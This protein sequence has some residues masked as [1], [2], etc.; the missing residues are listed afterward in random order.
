LRRT[1]TEVLL[2]GPHPWQNPVDP[3][4]VNGD[5]EVTPLDVLIMINGLNAG[6]GGPLPTAPTPDY[7]PTQLIS[8]HIP[9]ARHAIRPPDFHLSA[10]CGGFRVARLEPARRSGG[11][12]TAEIA[13]RYV[14]RKMPCSIRLR[15]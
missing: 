3:F 11:M 15:F 4:D 8:R 5:W 1:G 2:T 9:Y 7:A 6:Q 12:E 10:C 13:I 14:R